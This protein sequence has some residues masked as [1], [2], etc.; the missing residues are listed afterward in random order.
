MGALPVVFL[1]HPGDGEVRQIS[2]GPFPF[3]ARATDAEDGDLAASIQWTSDVEGLLGVGA[4]IDHVP[5]PVGFHVITASV[6][7]SDGGVGSAS[8]TLEMVP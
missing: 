5:E 6:T 8:V 3:I 2:A 1:D 4:R 7:D